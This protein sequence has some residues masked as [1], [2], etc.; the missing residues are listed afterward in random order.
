M[1]CKESPRG[2][3]H[4]VQTQFFWVSATADSGRLVVAGNFRHRCQNGT[5]HTAQNGL[6]LKEKERLFCRENKPKTSVPR[7]RIELGTL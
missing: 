5:R 4:E 3:L 6:F 1:C 7:P 2:L